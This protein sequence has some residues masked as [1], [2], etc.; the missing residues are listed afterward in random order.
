MDHLEDNRSTATDVT[1]VDRQHR[2]DTDGRNNFMIL[3]VT[4]SGIVSPNRKD[5]NHGCHRVELKTLCAMLH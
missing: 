3:N 5:R 4:H 2:L 1:Q